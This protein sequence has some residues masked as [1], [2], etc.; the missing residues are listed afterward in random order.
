M[1][2][3][4]APGGNERSSCLGSMGLVRGTGWILMEFKL[5]ARGGLDLEV[6]L[7]E[8]V[9]SLEGAPKKPR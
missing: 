9:A 1:I 6:L 8:V 4:S 2:Q 7:G 3:D 5:W